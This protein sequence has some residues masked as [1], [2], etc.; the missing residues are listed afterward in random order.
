MRL[1]KTGPWQENAIDWIHSQD[2]A[3]PAEPA[4]GWHV[5]RPS[6]EAR[7]H[8]LQIV[9]DFADANFVPTALNITL[10]RG[11]ELD[12]QRG[13]KTVELEILADGSIELSKCV[14]GVAISEITLEKPGW[15]INEAFDWIEK[16]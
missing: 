9:R 16:P 4:T 10:D 3:V 2:I 14:D 8:A 12:W 1:S 15:R 5:A 11:I 6:I 7:A 13:R